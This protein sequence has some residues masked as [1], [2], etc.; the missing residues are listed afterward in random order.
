MVK[1]IGPVMS[2]IARG[3]LAGAITYKCGT[4]AAKKK[5]KKNLR[6]DELNEQQRTFK[7]GAWIWDNE[8]T[9]EDK[10][11]WKEVATQD[12]F[13]LRCNERPLPIPALGIW[14]LSELYEKYRMNKQVGPHAYNLFMAYFLTLGEY[15]WPNYPAPPPAGWKPKYRIEDGKVIY[16]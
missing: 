11:K 13:D 2:L 4:V 10:K 8:M 1:L 5:T 7:D 12:Y 16:E 15:G 3:T 14:P 9:P 6:T